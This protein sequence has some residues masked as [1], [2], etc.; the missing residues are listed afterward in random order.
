MYD[1]PC[2]ALHRLSHGHF[3]SRVVSRPIDRIAT[4]NKS[5]QELPH[6]NKAFE[7]AASANQPLRNALL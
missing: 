2:L 4:V 1:E 6:G 3:R 7:S 5:V